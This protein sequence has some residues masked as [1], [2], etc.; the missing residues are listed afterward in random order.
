MQQQ[1]NLKKMNG[2]EEA[3]QAEPREQL[4]IDDAAPEGQDE[5]HADSTQNARGQSLPQPSNM[6]SD[7]NA[8]LFI[9][10]GSSAN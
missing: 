10:R 8:M 5:P 1:I 3:A 7:S 2:Q 6:A 9:E 4:Q